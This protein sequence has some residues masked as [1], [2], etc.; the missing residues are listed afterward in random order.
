[1]PQVRVEVPSGKFCNGCQWLNRG[2][3]LCRLFDVLCDEDSEED[4][5]SKIIKHGL[6][7]VGDLDDYNDDGSL[8]ASKGSNN[9]R[10]RAKVVI[11]IETDFDYAEEDDGVPGPDTLKF[12]IDEDINN[13]KSIA[14]AIGDC[15]VIDFHVWREK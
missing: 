1:M 7:P 6:C 5:Y 14:G 12:C 15:K 4:R 13:D 8:C 3:V 10:V 11:E 9:Y 2:T